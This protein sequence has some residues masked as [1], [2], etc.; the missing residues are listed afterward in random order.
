MNDQDET[1]ELRL[2]LGDN[3]T[4]VI[5]TRHEDDGIPRLIMGFFEPSTANMQWPID[6]VGVRLV[7]YSKHPEST[8]SLQFWHIDGRTYQNFFFGGM[9]YSNAVT[10]FKKLGFTH[11][12]ER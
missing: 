8:C 9:D 1:P 6:G 11:C 7:R 2:S 3:G 5:R 10:Y 4:L 12:D